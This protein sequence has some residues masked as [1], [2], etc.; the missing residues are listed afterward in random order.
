MLCDADV[1]AADL[2]LILEPHIMESHVFEGAWLA[3]INQDLCAS[4]GICT[5]YCRFD[6]IETDESGLRQINPYAC[7]GCRLCERICP[8]KAINSERSTNN[9]WFVSTTRAGIM[10]H[11]SMGPGEENSGKLVTRVRNKAREIARDTGARFILTDGPPGTGCAAIAS[12]TG[13]DVVLLVM[14]SSISSLHDAQR[15]IELVRQ[16]EIPLYAIINKFDI[17]EETTLEIESCLAKHSIPVLCKIPFDTAVVKAML[18]GQSIHEFDPD[19]EI[20]HMF[21]YARNKLLLE[22]EVLG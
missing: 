2:H 4:C 17:H 7:E 12:I 1:D 9:S 21:A 5:E 15:L 11:A 20:S 6:A 18:N 8:S 14:E 16:F 13:T 22:I 10:T 3:R 19:S